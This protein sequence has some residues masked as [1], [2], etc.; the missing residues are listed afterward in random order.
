MTSLVSLGL[1]KKKKK[2]KII[3]K[4]SRQR[5]SSACLFSKA[6]KNNK[7]NSHNFSQNTLLCK[8]SN[9]HIIKTNAEK[10]IDHTHHNFAWPFFGFPAI[11]E[12]ITTHTFLAEK[13]DKFAAITHKIYSPSSI[14]KKL[15][16][17]FWFGL[18]HR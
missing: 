7:K 4:A 12:I 11:D 2:K 3:C 8:N 13:H 6:D 16:N 18:K 5:Q 14:R 9:A 15:R 17:T 1:K 10:R